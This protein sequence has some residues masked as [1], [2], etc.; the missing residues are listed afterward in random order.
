MAKADQG[1]RGAWRLADA[2]LLFLLF[3]FPMM[4]ILGRGEGTI[5]RPTLL[6]WLLLILPLVILPWLWRRA[7]PEETAE[8]HAAAAQRVERDAAA[9]EEFRALVTPVVD[10]RRAYVESGVPMIEGHLRQEPARA[11][12]SLEALFAPLHRTPLV[13]DRGKNGVRIVA[14]PAAVDHELR[15]RPSVAINI[16]LFLATVATTIWA[17]ALHQGVNLLQQPGLYMVGVPYAAALL[18]ILGVHEFGHY[19][20]GRWRGVNVTLPYFIPVPMG[21][22]TLPTTQQRQRSRNSATKNIDNRTNKS[23]RGSANGS[24]RRGRGAPSRRDL[25]AR[26]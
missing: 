26:V 21:L 19:V 8:A 20:T 12:A 22:G 25:S 17:G 15:R 23:C 14:L 24:D 13:E 1:R 2:V 7:E 16:V 10:V 18:A 4:L 3:L 11:F 5:D 9:A 6:F